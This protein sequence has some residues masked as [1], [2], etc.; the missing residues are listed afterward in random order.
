[1]QT[2]NYKVKRSTQY[3]PEHLVDATAM[4]AANIEDAYLLAGVEDY[5]AKDCMNHAI[6]FMKLCWSKDA[7][8]GGQIHTSYPKEDCAK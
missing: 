2:M 8:M 1:M 3:D 4:I 6:E 7:K 5:T